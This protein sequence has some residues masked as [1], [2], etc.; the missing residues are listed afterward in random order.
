MSCW[1]YFAG[2]FVPH[3]TSVSQSSGDVKSAEENL[4]SQLKSL[5]HIDANDPEKTD[6]EILLAQM[7][8]SLNKL[9]VDI[10]K[11]NL[12]PKNSIGCFFI[13]NSSE[14]LLQLRGHFDSGLMKDV[15]QEIFTLLS[16]NG[17]QLVIT[18]LKLDHEEFDDCLQRL[19][20]LSGNGQ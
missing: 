15:L 7:E 5:I 14:E 6:K 17:D 13:C 18:E 16:K 12:V 3:A 19:S 2:A 20:Q 1:L 9:G 8:S 10:S 11:W 4:V